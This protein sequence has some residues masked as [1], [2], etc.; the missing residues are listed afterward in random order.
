MSSDYQI[1]IDAQALDDAQLEL[2]TQLEEEEQQNILRQQ[3]EEAL[4]QQQE[5]VQAEVDDPRNKE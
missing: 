2:E 4:L 3:Q 1:D 5:Q